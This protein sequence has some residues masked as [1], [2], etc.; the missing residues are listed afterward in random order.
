MGVGGFLLGLD[1]YYIGWVYNVFIVQ[2]IHYRMVSLLLKAF[3]II[4]GGNSRLV[5]C[6]SRNIARILGICKSW[7]LDSGLDHGLDYGLD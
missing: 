5:G 1:Y 4:V 7:T 2:G 6:P 3:N